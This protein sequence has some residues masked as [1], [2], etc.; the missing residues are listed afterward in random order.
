L[1]NLLGVGALFHARELLSA[2]RLSI[3]LVGL[4]LTGKA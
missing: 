2:L 4:T 1:G 3:V